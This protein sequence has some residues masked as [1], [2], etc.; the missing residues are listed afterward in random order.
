MFGQAYYEYFT[1]RIRL[2]LNDLGF[3]SGVIKLLKFSDKP[4]DEFKCCYSTWA[5]KAFQDG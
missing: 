2:D 1:G 3:L 5:H 4:K